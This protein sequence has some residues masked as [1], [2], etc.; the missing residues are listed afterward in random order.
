[1][2]ITLGKIS[3]DGDWDVSDVMGSITRNNPACFTNHDGGFTQSLNDILIVKLM[4][5]VSGVVELENPQPFVFFIP[6]TNENP[7]W[8]QYTEESGDIILEVGE[9]AA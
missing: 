3:I 7:Y 5:V 4:E 1:M 8:V 2:S 9:P 6:C